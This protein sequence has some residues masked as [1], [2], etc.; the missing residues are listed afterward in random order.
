[1]NLTAPAL[2]RTGLSCPPVRNGVRITDENRMV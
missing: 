1:M 2:D